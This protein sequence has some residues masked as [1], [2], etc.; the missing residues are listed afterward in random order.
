M[1]CCTGPGYSG[2]KPSLT[3]DGD[4][5]VEMSRH[6]QTL[7]GATAAV[8]NIRQCSHA[9]TLIALPDAHAV[10]CQ[11]AMAKQPIS[12]ARTCLGDVAHETRIAA[13]VKPKACIHVRLNDGESHMASTCS[14]LLPCNNSGSAISQ[15]TKLS[16]AS[17]GCKAGPNPDSP[18]IRS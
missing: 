1:D 5:V 18:Y 8:W 7:D 14:R 10:A 11:E 15:A 13:T 9:A 3:F 12:A 17:K 4:R 16:G 2:P 6:G